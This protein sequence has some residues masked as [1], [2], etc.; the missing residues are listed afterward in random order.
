ML[1]CFLGN[2]ILDWPL[3]GWKASGRN[4]IPDMVIR[5]GTAVGVILRECRWRGIPSHLGF[6][7]LAWCLGSGR[8]PPKVW[9]RI[10]CQG[11]EGHLELC[12]TGQVRVGCGG[13]LSGF[14]VFETPLGFYQGCGP[15]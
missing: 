14:Q 15:G 12:W 5:R 1:V 7:M 3:M 4:V 2:R 10:R 13:A 6:R 11:E 8:L 9:T